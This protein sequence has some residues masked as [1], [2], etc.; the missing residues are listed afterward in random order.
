MNLIKFIRD[1]CI[2]LSENYSS[3]PNEFKQ[4]F[5]ET[6]FVNARS[7][8]YDVCEFDSEVNQDFVDYE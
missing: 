6:D 4:K 7:Y 3:M 1:L 5:P 2:W 8:L